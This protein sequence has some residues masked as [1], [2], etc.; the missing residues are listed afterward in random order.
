MNRSTNTHRRLPAFTMLELIVATIAST[1]LLAGLG[2]VMFIARQTAYAPTAAAKRAKAADIVNLIS[3][4]LRY[5]TII[6]QQTPQILE[7][8]VAD[9]NND[10]TAEKIHYEWSGTAGDPL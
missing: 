8:I 7:F 2:S 5:A 1:F 3:D 6:T 9:R 10:G 4:E